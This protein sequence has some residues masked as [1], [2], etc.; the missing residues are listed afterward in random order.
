MGHECVDCPNGKDGAA[1]TVRRNEILRHGWG[2]KDLMEMARAHS[3]STELSGHFFEPLR[4][5]ANIISRP[6]KK[7]PTVMGLDRSATRCTG[8]VRSWLL[9]GSSS[10]SCCT[11]ELG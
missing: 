11:H 9:T 4:M 7:L 8:L 6:L 3:S 5:N 10:G 1:D 2:N